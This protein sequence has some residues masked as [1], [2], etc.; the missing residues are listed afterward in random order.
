MSFLIRN[1]LN[2][3]IFTI[4]ASLIG[5]LASFE[6]VL[7]KIA[8]LENAGAKLSCDI[9]PFASCGTVMEN[10]Q[11]E[12]FGFPNPL[13][14]IIC[15]PIA[16]LI[17][18][19]MVSKVDLPR[20]I[21]LGFNAGTFLGAVFIT[22]LFTQSVWAIGILCPWCIVVWAA[23]I[24]LFVYTTVY[25]IKEGCYGQKFKDSAVGHYLVLVPTLIVI[26]WYFIIAAS[27]AFTFRYEFSL[28][29]AGWGW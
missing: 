9:S 13:L 27:I 11:S 23:H 14:G 17:G 12:L 22:W 7:G 28:L 1:R 19:L 29:F 6:L 16:L 10:W 21:F 8:K 3:G 24:P 25:A 20:W 4:I 26:L 2:Y 5:F 18:V 15:F